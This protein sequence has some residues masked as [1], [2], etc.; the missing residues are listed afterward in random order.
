MNNPPSEK[1]IDDV[2]ERL[3]WHDDDVVLVLHLPHMSFFRFRSECKVPSELILNS[4][5][6][7]EETW[8][9]KIPFLS[10]DGILFTPEESSD[11]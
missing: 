6:W 3:T 7:K 11:S 10:S 1:D 5:I 9:V 8:E 2:I 4:S